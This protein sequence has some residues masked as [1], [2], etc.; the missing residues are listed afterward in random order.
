MQMLNITTKQIACIRT[1][2]SK[3]GMSDA[4][5]RKMLGQYGVNST[6]D[7]SIG[8]AGSIIDRLRGSKGG[9]SR[10]KDDSATERQMHLIG[11]L[12]DNIDWKDVKGFEKW[13][14]GRMHLFTI[15][16][17]Q[18]AS[19]VIEGLKGILKI[20]TAVIELKALPFPLRLDEDYF[21]NKR[22]GEIYP[23]IWVYDI[24]Q[25]RL[26]RVINESYE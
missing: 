12:R 23:Y 18:E 2:A 10:I 15:R 8:Q 3:T 7:L 25:R 24:A 26:H 4:E 19:R 16:T 17:K 9:K 22:T 14:A 20:D 13:L 5:Y 6:K 11:I 1:L 21:I